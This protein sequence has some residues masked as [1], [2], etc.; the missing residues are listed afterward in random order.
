MIGPEG[1]AAAMS[2]PTLDR[3][4]FLR[5]CVAAALVSKARAA[6]R[7]RVVVAG[8]GIVGASIAFHLARAGAD[9]TVIDRQGPATH[10]SRGSF[11][12]INATWSKQPQAYHALNQDG[13]ARW[14]LLQPQLNLPVRWGGSLE[15]NADRA[16]QAELADRVAEQ[17]AWGEKTRL[18][19]AGDLAE[20]EPNVDFTRLSQVVH[21]A[22]DGATDPVAA[23]QAFL[24]GATALGA[25]LR[26]PCELTGVLLAGG[27]LS[28]VQTSHGDIAADRLVL[29]TGA[30]AD[31]G[32]R[33]A[34]WDVP[35]RDEPGLTA[36]TAPTPRLIHRVLWMPG[37]HLHQR[38]DGRIVL[39][40]EAGPPPNDAH[41][42]RIAG[43][44][45]EFPARDIAFQHAER[46]RIAAQ[47]YVPD[48]THVDFEDVRVC[49]RPM[50]LDGYPVLGASPA[51][52]DVYFAV[53]HSGV[54]LAPIVGELA[55]RE[56]VEGAPLE[57]LNGFRPDRKLVASVVR[58]WELV[59]P[60]SGR[61]RT[62]RLSGST[63]S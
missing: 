30:A 42:A 56:I 18:L 60:E 3:R 44:P 28:A 26:H 54:T 45:N 53:M 38:D 19:D 40:E 8:A 22:N 15:G 2:R 48:L 5:L 13:V 33:F 43:R 1:R 39:G 27:R 58:E 52:P 4:D 32:K 16:R 51:R 36:I 46:L 62:R 17:V 34:D 47:R 7:Q 9:V 21:S 61:T 50:P 63:H 10:A 35:Q 55:A 59:P 6:G 31:A 41:A 29:A 20:L 25:R 11:A 14:K 24:D 37:V 57:R 49:W 23:T 12:W